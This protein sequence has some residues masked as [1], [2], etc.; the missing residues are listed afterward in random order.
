MTK[1]EVHLIRI[2]SGMSDWKGET[3]GNAFEVSFSGEIRYQVAAEREVKEGC[4]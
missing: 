2:Y 1:L 3:A 4:L